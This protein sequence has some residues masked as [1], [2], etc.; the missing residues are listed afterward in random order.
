MTVNRIS[1]FALHQSTL[2]DVSRVQTN[3]ADLQNQISSG[4]KTD[5][6]QGL[7]TQVEQF[8]SLESRIARSNN[9]A[10]SNALTL[11]RLNT[12]GVVLDGI[13]ETV[14]DVEDLI[15]LRRGAS[16]GDTL[17][18]RTQLLHLRD[19]LT[20][21]LNT[22]F[23]GRYIFGGTRTN[24]PPVVNNPETLVPGTPDRSYYQGGSEDLFARLDDN[25]EIDY[26]V[27]ADAEGFQKVI[28]GIAQALTSDDAVASSSSVLEDAQS[29]I[30]EGLDD[31]VRERTE[32]NANIVTVEAVT[33]RHQELSLYWEGVKSELI[34]TD[35]VAAS[36]QVAIDQTILQASFQSFATINRLRLIDFL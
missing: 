32:V 5:R 16:D 15:V 13:I 30:Q 11:S 35:I 29:L 3:L 10:E 19:R 34:D 31:I 17:Q 33:A 27:R 28:A 2:G 21:S 9:Y 8:V 36:T 7:G 18:F 26:A 1:T 20:E 23:E 12:S 4:K 14:D 6:F 25:I 24:V 22:N